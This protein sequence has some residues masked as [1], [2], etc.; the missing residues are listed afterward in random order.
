[1]VIW[2]N[3][4]RLMPGKINIMGEKFFNILVKELK[5]RGSTFRKKVL[6]DFP[7]L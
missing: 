4:I 5:V 7:Y 1:M 6:E 2:A 3:Q